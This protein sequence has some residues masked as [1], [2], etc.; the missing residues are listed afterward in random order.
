MD[1]VAAAAGMLPRLRERLARGASRNGRFS[2]DL[3][4]RLGL[5][6]HLLNEGIKDVFEA[7]PVEVAV[8]VEP[9]LETGAS[10]RRTTEE[11]CEKLRAMY[12]AWA[13]NRHMQTEE[14]GG[15]R[16]DGPVLVIS[17]FGAHRSLLRECGLHILENPGSGDGGGR[18]SARVRLVTTPLGDLPAG[19]MHMQILAALDKTPRPNNVVR[20]YR[21]EP[22]PLVRSADGSRRS[23]KLDAVLRGDFDLL[24]AD[25]PSLPA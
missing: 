16:A 3:V 13:H 21:A 14:F 2:R 4:S 22:A 6:L 10:D 20:R 11:W 9:T 12:R 23:G 19:R 18:N 8:V 1:R 7:A 24:L 15:G 5:Q 25:D 17:G